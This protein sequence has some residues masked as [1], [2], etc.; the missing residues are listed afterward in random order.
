VAAALQV[1]AEETLRQLQAQRQ[2]AAIEAR[3]LLRLPAQGAKPRLPELPAQITMQ[4]ELQPKTQEVKLSKL[5]P[6]AA[7]IQDRN[8]EAQ[9]EHILQV[10]VIQE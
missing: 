9:K 6:E 1:V 10:T 8:T 3:R 5:K 7:P 4:A 2:P